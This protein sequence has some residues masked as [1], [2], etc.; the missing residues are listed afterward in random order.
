MKPNVIHFESR[1]DAAIFTLATYGRE[2]SFAPDGQPIAAPNGRYFDVPGPLRR[3]LVICTITGAFVVHQTLNGWLG[4]H[5]MTLR[6]GG[7]ATR[8]AA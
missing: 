4:A 1:T 7:A 5:V 6:F 2:A 3:E 8:K